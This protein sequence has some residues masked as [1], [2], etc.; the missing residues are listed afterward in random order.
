MVKHIK[1]YAH[2]LIHPHRSF[3]TDLTLK[4]FKG[5][6]K[7]DFEQAIRV[8]YSDPKGNEQVLKVYKP[9]RGIYDEEF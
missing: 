9:K 3:A 4:D 8:V 2:Q 5:S 7:W 6:L 1:V